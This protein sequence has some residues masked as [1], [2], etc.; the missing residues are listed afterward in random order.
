M[1]A[2]AWYTPNIGIPKAKESEKR[3]LIYYHTSWC[4]ACKYMEN[5]TFKDPSLKLDSVLVPIVIDCD[6]RD[7]ITVKGSIKTYSQ[8]CRDME[9]SA[10]PTFKVF[11]SKGRVVRTFVGPRSTREFK[12]LIKP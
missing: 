12:E 11:N 2:S 4:G 10:Y 1:I 9:I 8:F 7:T 6:S 5:T 3:F